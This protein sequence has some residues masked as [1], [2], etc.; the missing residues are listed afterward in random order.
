MTNDELQERLSRLE[1]LVEALI[2]DSR[3]WSTEEQRQIK[4]DAQSILYD[5]YYIS[6]IRNL[7]AEWYQARQDAKE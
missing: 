3:G 5:D 1:Q 4:L 2:L 7:G 6:K